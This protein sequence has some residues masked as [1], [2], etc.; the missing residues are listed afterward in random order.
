MV[1]TGCDHASQQSI[2]G[3]SYSCPKEIKL[4]GGNH[5]LN[6]RDVVEYVSDLGVLDS[7]FLYARHVDGKN[8]LNPPMQEDFKFVE[9]A[10]SE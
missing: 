4:L 5:V 2:A 7:L 6:V 8:A 1:T 3:A 10:L 9:Q